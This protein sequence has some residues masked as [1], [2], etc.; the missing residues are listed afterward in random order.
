[1]DARVEEESPFIVQEETLESQLVFSE[2]AACTRS[3]GLKCMRTAISEEVIAVHRFWLA[4]LAAT[5]AICI[6]GCERE[7]QGRGPSQELIDPGSQSVVRCSELQ[8]VDRAG[9]ARS[10]LKTTDDGA[11][12]FVMTDIEQKDRIWLTVSDRRVA[13]IRI[14]G[15]DG[16]WRCRM[17]DAGTAGP[18]IEMVYSAK[19]PRMVLD[20]LPDGGPRIQMYDWPNTLRCEMSCRTYPEEGLEGF[21]AQL[22]SRIVLWDGTGKLIGELGK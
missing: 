15:V 3:V 19:G 14:G 18:M 20:Q 7:F 21:D 10:R 11:V 4:L 13:E 6:V 5:A 2:S 22:R 9:R 12:E 1:M 16:N 17:Y 8:L